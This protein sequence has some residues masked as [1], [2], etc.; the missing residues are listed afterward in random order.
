MKNKNEP[1]NL[2]NLVRDYRRRDMTEGVKN[3]IT[4]FNNVTKD[5]KNYNKLGVYLAEERDIDALKTLKLLLL[6]DK[7]GKLLKEVDVN[8]LCSYIYRGVQQKENIVSCL[9]INP[10]NYALEIFDYIVKNYDVKYNFTYLT[11]ESIIDL[12]LNSFINIDDDCENIF[13]KRYDMIDYKL[14]IIDY[15]VSNRLLSKNQVNRVRNQYKYLLENSHA[16]SKEQLWKIKYFID[17]QKYICKLEG[18]MNDKSFKGL[19]GGSLYSSQDD[20]ITIKRRAKKELLED[21]RLSYDQ[22]SYIEYEIPRLIKER[23]I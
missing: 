7:S 8:F 3:A 18:I 9:A 23:K 17:I 11:G 2:K 14:E 1:L 12:W 20:E 15:L 4:I 10:Q 6:L 21:Y 5:L 19:S 13:Y 22:V 16:F